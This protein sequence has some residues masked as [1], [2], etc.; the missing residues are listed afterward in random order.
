LRALLSAASRQNAL[1]VTGPAHGPSVAWPDTA[2]HSPRP[3]IRKYGARRRL[4]AGIS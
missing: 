1:N 4:F 3:H 2:A